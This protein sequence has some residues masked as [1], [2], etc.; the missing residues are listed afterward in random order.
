MS[1]KLLLSIIVVLLITNVATMLLWRNDQSNESALDDETIDTDKPVASIGGKD[2]SYTDWMKALKSN[3]GENQLK[4]MVDQQV[5]KTLAKQNGI[6]VS[7]KVIKRDIALLTTM[8]GVTSETKLK[9]L[10]QKWT[11]DITYRY[12]LEALL[13]KD[14]T[15]SDDEVQ[16]YYTKYDGQYQFNESVQLSHILVSDMET[17]EKVY[18]ELEDGAT[19]SLLAKEYSIDEATKDNGGYLGFN[20]VDTEFLPDNYFDIVE[21][22]EEYSYSEPFVTTNGI[23]ILYLHKSLPEITFTFDELKPY[24]RNELALQASNQNL[25]A[26]RLWDELDIKWIYGE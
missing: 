4:S 25:I 10:E 3:Y 12:Q 2:I 19:F 16:T 20:S 13:A 6:T 5:V 23:A 24:I 22:L 9:E 1:K 18:S 26:D 21:G 15:V 7:D 14:I 17:A 8:Q 11:E